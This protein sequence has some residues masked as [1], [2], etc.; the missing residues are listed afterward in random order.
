MHGE[1]FPKPERG[2]IESGA[3]PEP[4]VREETIFATTLGTALTAVVLT[5]SSGGAQNGSL[6]SLLAARRLADGSVRFIAD[7]G[8]PRPDVL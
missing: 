7:G 2:R 3:P 8:N 6:V 5:A 1:S 4:F